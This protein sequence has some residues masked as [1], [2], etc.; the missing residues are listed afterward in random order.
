MSYDYRMQAYP[1]QW[2]H[3]QPDLNRLLDAAKVGAMVGASGAAAYNLHRVRKQ[4]IDW[5]QGLRDTAKVSLKAGAATAAATAVGHMFSK[6]PLL[7]IAATL[8]TATAVMYALN[9][10]KRKQEA[11]DE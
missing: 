10:G 9:N 6:H 1:P 2:V 3:D 5:Q 4:E 8:T 7:S 11:S